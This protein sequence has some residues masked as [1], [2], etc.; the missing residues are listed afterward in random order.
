MGVLFFSQSAE[1]SFAA[2][3]AVS[4]PGVNGSE[5][6]V[7]AG[8]RGSFV[9]TW[10]GWGDGDSRRVKTRIRSA[11]GRLG[12]VQTL[13][14]GGWDAFR[15]Q[16]A[17][18]GNGGAV[19]VWLAFDGAHGRIQTRTR[20]ARGVLGRVRTLSSAGPEA[21]PMVAVDRD[22]DASFVWIR[23]DGRND[24]VQARVRSAAGALGPVRTLSAAG[25]SAHRAQVSVGAKGD[26][27]MLWLLSGGTD[28][29]QARVRSDAGTL[30]PVRT[31]SARGR[32]AYGPQVVINRHGDALF[33]W[34]SSA[35]GDSR[36]EAR[37]RTAAGM[38]G[39][40]RTISGAGWSAGVSDLALDA[41]GNA[42]VIWTVSDGEYLWIQGRVRSAGGALGRIRN[43]SSRLPDAWPQVV[44]D[45]DGD[46]VIT[47]LQSDGSARFSKYWIKARKRS[48]SGVL[49]PVRTIS[50]LGTTP[51]YPAVAM[52]A[53]GASVVTW[54]KS[55]LGANDRVEASYGP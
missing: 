32:W 19:F 51:S 24:R 38:L 40:I 53:N 49:G 12:P 13:S 33:T 20:S 37:T 18:D 50:S 16:V 46:A 1:A 30:G 2:P 35:R 14:P 44:V 42:L 17:V 34:T 55:A 31:L 6:Q 26:A 39:P 45:G 5:P 28:R 10:A 15:P 41:R 23:S 9:F 29:L 47:W 8:H 25:R 21:Y 4:P 54:Q 36:V 52:S 11:A 3:S 27:F 48:A 43:L 22:G 7:A